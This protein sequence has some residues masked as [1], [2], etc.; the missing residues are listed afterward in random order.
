M[1]IAGH[2]PQMKKARTPSAQR[3]RRKTT[4]RGGTPHRRNMK[5]HP[6]RNDLRRV[7]ALVRICMGQL[8]RFSEFLVF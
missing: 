7:F 4:D 1:R 2:H 3:L 8:P 6:P 5:K